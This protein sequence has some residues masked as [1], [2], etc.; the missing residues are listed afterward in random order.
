MSAGPPPLGPAGSL[1]DRVSLRDDRRLLPLRRPGHDEAVSGDH[2]KRRRTDAGPGHAANGTATANGAHSVA[3]TAAMG[4]LPAPDARVTSVPPPPVAAQCPPHPGFIKGMCIRCGTL[5][6]EEQA[7][8]GVAL[9]CV[10]TTQSS[11][12]QAVPWEGSRNACIDRR[13]G[14][15]AACSHRM[16]LGTSDS[17]AAVLGTTAAV[18]DCTRRA[19]G[20]TGA[21]PCV[22]AC[23]SLQSRTMLTISPRGLVE[24]VLRAMW[25]TQCP[26]CRYIHQGLTISH[27]EAARLRADGLARV[28]AARRLL[29]VLDLDHTLLN[30]TRLSEVRLD[31]N[32]RPS[33]LGCSDAQKCKS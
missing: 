28:L 20:I 24:A 23:T 19:L 11:T 16:M 1:P 33:P 17:H 18:S 14:S 21:Q 9:R 10:F 32:L 7:Q 6:S 29:L 8:D 31:A 5:Q 15:H 22:P 26:L 12:F 2:R 3:A 13:L 25:L 4:L 27:G 30:S